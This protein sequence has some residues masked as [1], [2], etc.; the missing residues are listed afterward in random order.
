MKTRPSDALVARL[1]RIGDE[2]LAGEAGSPGAEALLEQ[3][4]SVPVAARERARR[5]PIVVAFAAALALALAVSV[6]ALGIGQEV[7]S[8]FANGVVFIAFS[9]P[10]RRLLVFGAV[11]TSNVAT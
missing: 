7:V 1:A 3:I 2:E 9:Y 8:F 10:V 5:R 11:S 6:P 4:I